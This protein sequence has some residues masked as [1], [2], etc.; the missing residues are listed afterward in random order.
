[1]LYRNKS[2]AAGSGKALKICKIIERNNLNE[3]K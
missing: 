2:I 1:V 3:L